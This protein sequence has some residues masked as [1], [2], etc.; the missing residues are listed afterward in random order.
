[1]KKRMTVIVMTSSMCN[2]DCVYCYMKASRKNVHEIDVSAIPVLI[3]HCSADFDEVEFCWHGGEPLMVGKEFYRSAI[4]AQQKITA[5]RGTEFRNVM[6]TN[7]L[8]LDEEWVDL[9]KDA[10]IS[11]GF[12]F[13]AP[14]EI[15]ALHR[16]DNA[17]KVIAAWELVRSANLPV[18]AICVISKYNVHKA[19]EI[20]DFFSAQNIR[21]YSFLPLRAV[22]APAL[23]PIPDNQELFELFRDTF[24]LWSSR[25]NDIVSIEPLS[26]MIQALINNKPQLCSFSGSCPDTMISIDQDG[27]VV[28]CCSLVEDKFVMGN[29]F[30]DP[31][32]WI[33]EHKKGPLVQLRKIAVANSCVDCEYLPICN[34]G[35]R[36]DAYWETGRYDGKYPYCETRKLTFAYLKNQLERFG[37]I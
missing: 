6:Q 16:G 32:A 9:L 2:I 25:E 8:L 28:P 1:M 20:F 13:D 10:N 21:S 3:D 7:G 35:C 14:P 11:F 31:L 37:V 24:N 22:P 30:A 26:T 29:I 19:R 12:S 5:L 18:G 23:P 27:N 15:H 36:A 33:L 34:G 17:Q 4:R